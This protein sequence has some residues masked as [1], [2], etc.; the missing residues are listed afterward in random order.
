MTSLDRSQPPHFWGRRD[1]KRAPRWAITRPE[2]QCAGG[3]LPQ[4]AGRPPNRKHVGQN[5]NNAQVAWKGPPPPP[6]HTPQHSGIIA[7]LVLRFLPQTTSPLV[8]A[9]PVHSANI[10]SAVASFARP[11]PYQSRRDSDSEPCRPETV[12]WRASANPSSLSWRRPWGSKS[13][14]ACPLRN[15][16]L[17]R[18]CCS[19]FFFARGS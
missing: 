17:G 6:H 4:S 5:I 1:P 16:G 13:T 3:K 7:S 19:L 11:Q 12:G 8:P 14:L 2:L 9:L 18:F 15:H 10:A